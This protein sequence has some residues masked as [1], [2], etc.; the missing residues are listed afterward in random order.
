MPEYDATYT[1]PNC[2]QKIKGKSEWAGRRAQCRKCQHTFVLAGAASAPVLAPPPPVQAAGA[3]DDIPLKPQTA[4][5][6]TPPLPPESPAHRGSAY[7][8][9]AK[10]KQ[11]GQTRPLSSMERKMLGFSAALLIGAIVALVLPHFGYELQFGKPDRRVTID[12]VGAVVLA[13]M[14][15]VVAGLTVGNWYLGTRGV[16]RPGLWIA[17]AAVGTLVL[18]GCAGPVLFGVL[19]AVMNRPGRTTR[20]AH[21]TPVAGSLE[22]PPR[23]VS[24]RPNAGVTLPPA[25]LSA[26]GASTPPQF[27]PRP[28][29]GDDIPKPSALV[30]AEHNGLAWTVTFNHMGLVRLGSALSARQLSH[31][32]GGIDQAGMMTWKVY[33]IEDLEFLLKELNLGT[34]REINTEKRTAL[35]NIP[36]QTQHGIAREEQ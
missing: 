8:P 19:N 7:R 9:R 21:P 11:A 36:F 35:L 30:E 10:A 25:S 22:S 6:I 24:P 33:P 29:P 26:E 14:G 1:C 31:W 20:V 28:A 3:D 27:P 32:P 15:L 23:N 12:T 13:I 16:K 5:P 34:V 18:L 2:E 4:V 17:G